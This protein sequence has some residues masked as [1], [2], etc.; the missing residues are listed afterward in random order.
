MPGH[1]LKTITSREMD[2]GVWQCIEGRTSG[3]DLVVLGQRMG[4]INAGTVQYPDW[5]V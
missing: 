1:W 3:E 4:N 2:R 5:Q